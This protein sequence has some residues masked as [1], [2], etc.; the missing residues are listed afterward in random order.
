MLLA[1]T[2]Y[3]LDAFRLMSARAVSNRPKDLVYGVDDVPPAGTLA[4]LALQHLALVAIF[5]I[6]AVTIARLAGLEGEAA[7]ALMSMTLLA[8]AVGTAA[9]AWG[10]FGIGS[11]YL[12]PS[13]T[14]TIL[15]PPTAAALAGGAGLAA[16]MGMTMVSGLLA[17]ALSRVI[18]RLRPMFP[19]EI[20]GF[21]VFIVGL[22]VISLAMRNFLGIDPGRA[23][24]APGGG[25]SAL[26][27]AAAT[28]TVMVSLSVWGTRQLRL[29]S[30]LVGIA[31]G[32]GLSFLL[33][34]FDGGTLDAI[35]AAPLVAV[36]RP[37]TFG[38][39]FDAALLVPF[40]IA[41]VALALN[42]LGAVN[43][44]QKVNEVEWKRPDL[45][46]AGRGVLS[47]GFSCVVAGLLGGAGQA[48][49]S[50]AVGLSQATGATSRVIG[51]GIAGGLAAL[52]FLPQV[53]AVLLAMPEPVAGAALT[54]SGCFLVVNGV[55]M[56]ASRM[57]DARKV[58]VLGI[59]LSFGLARAL[60]PAH[61]D[62]AP[63]WLA[64]WVSSPMALGVS[65]AV[66]LNLVFRIGIWR[67]D[68]LTVDSADAD[69][70]QVATFLEDQGALSGARPE[71]VH[72]A[73]FAVLDTL[74]TLID[75]NMVRDTL[76]L[77]RHFPRL[78]IPG[79]LITV[80][81]R[82]DEFTLNV[83]VSYRGHLLEPRATR[84]SEDEILSGADGMLEFSRYMIGRSVDKVHATRHE[85][86]CILT[87]SLQN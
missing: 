85:D 6:V 20:T 15:L 72:R 84:P 21:V 16:V 65:L 28:L 48:A 19:P 41:A 49:T 36:P 57:L 12:V 47:D 22:S 45:E 33:G 80:R 26:F 53:S 61:F 87:L 56:I 69:L 9:Q 42:S 37:F 5:L 62:A 64:P 23:A 31:V 76:R 43:A 25:G 82:F 75:Q 30:P 40:S 50:G 35:A 39:A 17:M 13:T 11:G 73:R 44:A 60:F 34:L 52:A 54:F 78:D 32:Y 38:I 7:S 27:V 3:N 24:G 70:A 68:G 66:V 77:G 10:R 83:V 18:S 79:G 8:G 74:E 86:L 29:F 2:A 46:R 71:V 1:Q 51:F 63:D 14:T 59:A 58:F 55:Q 81:T 4:G 67:R